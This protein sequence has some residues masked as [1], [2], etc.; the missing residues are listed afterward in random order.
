M[1]SGCLTERCNLH[2][3]RRQAVASVSIG[4]SCNTGA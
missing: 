2:L 3:S 1:S 4:R